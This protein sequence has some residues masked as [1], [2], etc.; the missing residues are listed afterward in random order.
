MSGCE[1]RA[2]SDD[3]RY[4]DM[5]IHVSDQIAHDMIVERLDEEN[6]EY[7]I[8]EEGR[9]R[10]SRELRQ[11]Y[12]A[13]SERV[14]EHRHGGTWIQY[15]GGSCDYQAT[16]IA[17]LEERDLEYVIEPVGADEIEGDFVHWYPTEEHTKDVVYAE[18]D[19]R[20]CPNRPQ[21]CGPRDLASRDAAG[22]GKSCPDK[23]PIV[24]APFYDNGVIQGYRFFPGEDSD[25]FDSTGL[26]L[27]DLVTAVEGQPLTD[28]K[29]V[30]DLL[31]ELSSGNLVRVTVVREGI[32]QDI[33]LL[34]ADRESE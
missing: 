32:K 15:G 29:Q 3:S 25:L 27:G 9:I 21:D 18:V 28:V 17:V 7:W 6:V 4:M 20:E 1:F 33:E 31:G 5:S 13:I 16:L 12:D 34:K 22:D 30:D 14:F 2:K 24:S 23:G 11:A 8:D 19:A 26:E 10:I